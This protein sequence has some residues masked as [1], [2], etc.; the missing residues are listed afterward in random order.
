MPRLTVQICLWLISPI[1]YQFTGIAP[2]TIHLLL[3]EFA[4]LTVRYGPSF[5]LRLMAQVRSAPAIKR[6]KKKKKKGSITYGTDQSNEVNK[7]LC[8]N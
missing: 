2:L 4:V 7:V 1:N 3:T 6:E 8:I 5:L